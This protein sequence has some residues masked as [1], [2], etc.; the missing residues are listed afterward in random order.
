MLDLTPARLSWHVGVTSTV[1][2]ADTDADEELSATP[3]TMA[4]ATSPDSED[5]RRPSKKGKPVNDV[6]SEDEV[7]EGEGDDEEY[8]IEKILEAKR[9]VFPGVYLTSLSPNMLCTYA[10][11]GT[12]RIQSQMERLS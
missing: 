7:E 1:W 2:V 4:R 9:G 8:E 5:D 6:E 3:H 11:I 12:Y 10:C